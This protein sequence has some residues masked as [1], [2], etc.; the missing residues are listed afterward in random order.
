MKDVT[1]I[2][3]KYQEC[4]RHLWNTYFYPMI[5]QASENESDRDILETFDEVERALFSG[6]VLE[7]LNKPDYKEDFRKPSSI[8]MEDTSF[9]KQTIMQHISSIC[10]TREPHAIEC[11]KVIPIT[12]VP[13]LISRDR[14]GF[15][16]TEPSINRTEGTDIDLRFID[17][18]DWG[19]ELFRDL[20]Y[21]RLKIVSFP[22]HPEV[23]G[24][25]ALIE[26]MYC[27]VFL[28]DS[29][30]KCSPSVQVK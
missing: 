7:P 29:E 13:I 3:Q 11:L 10:S 15:R 24:R 21:F 23:E 8:S 18:F 14:R 5:D 17:Y 1:K 4:I 20:K 19:Q 26:T 27:Q 12:D 22:S 9:D 2:L 30:K 28:L 16:H 25:E 6:L